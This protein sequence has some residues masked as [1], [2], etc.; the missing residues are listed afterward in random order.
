MKYLEWNSIPHI[1]GGIVLTSSSNAILPDSTESFVTI[2]FPFSWGCSRFH[3]RD[4]VSLCPAQKNRQTKWDGN[5]KFGRQHGLMWGKSKLF[6]RDAVNS[7]GHKVNY[8]INQTKAMHTLTWAHTRKHT[9][10][11]ASTRRNTLNNTHKHTHTHI[12]NHQ[13]QHG[14]CLVSTVSTLTCN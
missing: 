4:K 2:F 13:H 1:L 6:Y 12:H 7:K 5:T 8:I 10:T 11:H 9:H 14:L 3:S